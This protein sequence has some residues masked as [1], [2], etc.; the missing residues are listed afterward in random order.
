M[1]CLWITLADPDPPRNGQF[2][3]SRGLIHGLTA[4]GMEVHVVG[5]TRPRGQHRHGQFADGVYWWLAP[6]QWSADHQPSPRWVSL[7][8]ALPQLAA[9]TN[10]PPMR[11]ILNERLTGGGSWDAIVFDSIC[12]GWAL[13]VVQQ[14]YATARVRPRLVYLSHNHEQSVAEQIAADTRPFW[15]RQ[16]KHVD[17]WKVGRLERWLVRHTDLITSNSPAD[18]EK[19][20]PS[21]ADR[22]V[23]FLPPGYG[24]R[25]IPSRQIGSQLPRRAI[26]VGSFDWIAKRTSLEEFLAVADP[27][28]A[29]AGIELDVVGNADESFLGR[30]RNKV[31]ATRLTG[32]V[33]DIHPYMEQARLALVPDLLGGFKL[34]ALDYVFNR[35]PI[36]AIAG[37][38][39][40]M[41]LHETES[42]FLFR[43]H[44]SL[45]E[46]VIKAID[47][48]DLLNR[49]QQAAYTACCDQF[50]WT[51]IGQRLMCAM[52]LVDH[53]QLTTHRAAPVT[54]RW[55][56]TPEVGSLDSPA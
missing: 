36:F 37:S 21:R 7:A 22:R 8:S 35:L 47:D 33:D 17:A 44:R 55:S 50:D 31:R 16:F 29:A 48:L 10:T 41:P 38:V 40:G 56:T 26:I 49:A 18:C 27:L 42:I 4:A 13:S 53:S 25:R 32:R 54:P 52:S 19:F 1:K 3:Y 6:H 34:K 24:G 12:V 2:L 39:P 30:L 46:G 14:H 9:Q 15:K 28:F 51:N 23:E 45:A 43:D 11:R 20:R 5:L